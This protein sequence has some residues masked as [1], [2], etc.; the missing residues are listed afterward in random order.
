MLSFWE[1][2][3]IGT[4]DFAIVG[5]GIMGLSLA[6]ELR[7]KYPNAGILVLERGIFPSGASTRNAGFA[8]FGSATEILHDIRLNGEEKT[9]EIVLARMEGIR[10]LRERLGDER[11]GFTSYGGYELLM[12][13]RLDASSLNYLNALTEQELFADASGRIGEFGFSNAVRQLVYCP[14]EGQV[15]TGLMMSNLLEL[16]REQNIRVWFGA[17]VCALEG[18]QVELRSSSGNFKLRAGKLF[19][20]TNAFAQELL[21]DTD[22]RPGRG[23]VLISKP[24]KGLKCKGSF[25]FE[26][27]FYYFRNVG[28]RLLFGGG[29]N[30]DMESEATTEFCI[31]EKI[32]QDLQQKI[33]SVILPYAEVE[34]EQVWQGIMG[35]SA[36][37]LPRLI[38]LNASTSYIM[39]CNGMGVALSPYMA[40]RIV[41]EL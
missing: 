4:P 39:A 2:R 7:A 34:I 23:Q 24:V 1:K 11:L 35:F 16:A 19:L 20:C 29:R 33:R 10:L 5:A 3:F 8:C 17:D 37:K 6:L 21:P 25:H 30:L 14:A 32:V 28:E 40:K 26:E 38:V 36:D 12:D 18:D 13:E 9:M 31:N 41:R 15:D 22:V 27:G